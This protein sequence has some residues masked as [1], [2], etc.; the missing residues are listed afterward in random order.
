MK[1]NLTQCISR[2]GYCSRRKAE[3]LIRSGKVQ[4]N[5]EI[6][7]LGRKVGP[8]D[9]I[10]IGNKNIVPEEENHYIVLNK[11]K[12][13]VS[14][15]R[16]FKGE[17][18]V[19]DLLPEEFRPILHMAGRLDK[20]STG[21]ALFTNDG[22]LTERLTHPRYGHEKEYFVKCKDPKSKYRI[23]DIRNKFLQG[24]DIGEGDG[25]VKVKKIH[26]IDNGRFR[27]VLAE[28]KKRQI[29][30]MFKATGLRVESLHRLR[31]GKLE[32]GGLQSGQWRE[33]P[34]KEAEKL[35]A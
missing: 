8:K 23:E 30:R 28:G 27:V 31:I 11:P 5:G 6:A 1:N 9:L 24:I 26:Y 3:E 17:K 35:L 13:Y 16:R 34:A 32:I 22:A 4:V 14:T 29:R 10:R 25:V 19:F 33:L 12:G 2:S 21:L 15:N 20:D 7:E 18:S